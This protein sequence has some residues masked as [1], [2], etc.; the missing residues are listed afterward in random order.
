MVI[1]ILTSVDM[2]GARMFRKKK[3]RLVCDNGCMAARLR[4]DAL[5]KAALH[6]P[7]I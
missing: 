1:D 2:K 5:F 6:G 7:R 3:V 4:E